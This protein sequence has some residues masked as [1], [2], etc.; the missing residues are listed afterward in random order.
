M[1]APTRTADTLVMSD[2]VPL[3]D[4]ARAPAIPGI[5]AR[6]FRDDADYELLAT[7]ICATM[8]ADGVPYQPNA[9]NLR[10]DIIAP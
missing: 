4:P 5:R 1:T 8:I 6:F 3:P 10:I 2:R 9:D 7:I